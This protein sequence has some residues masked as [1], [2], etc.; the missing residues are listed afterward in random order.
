M[1]TKLVCTSYWHVKLDGLKFN[2]AAVKTRLHDIVDSVA[3]DLTMNVKFVA[4]CCVF[5]TPSFRSLVTCLPKQVCGGLKFFGT[6]TR[7]KANAS[8]TQKCS[9]QVYCLQDPT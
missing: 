1:Y 9:T 2:D 5:G 6:C 7:P 3:T 4:A 8:I